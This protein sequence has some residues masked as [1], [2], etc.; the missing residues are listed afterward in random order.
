MK[1]VDVIIRNLE[2]AGIKA[3]LKIKDLTRRP[4]SSFRIARIWL[5]ISIGSIGF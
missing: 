5:T 3:I 4:R 1:A 2:E